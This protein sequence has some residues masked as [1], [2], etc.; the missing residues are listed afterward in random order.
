MDELLSEIE[1]DQEW[2]N[3][4]E[5]KILESFN[6]L[7]KIQGKDFRNKLIDAFNV[8]LAV[9]S[10]YILVISAVINKLHNASLLI[11]DIE[12][13]SDKRR[14]FPVAH[15]IFGTPS[16]INTANYIYFLAL[17]QLKSLNNSSL[18][19]IYN[20]EL[21]NL[22]R[23]QGM[24][25]YYRDNFICPSISQYLQLV[26]NKTSGL[27]RLSIKLLLTFSSFE[28]NLI[29]LI[30]KIGILFQIRDDYLNL[31]DS[32]SLN[33]SFAEDIT[34]GKFSFPIIHGILTDKDSIK[35]INILKQRTK[36]HDLKLYL[37][38]Y[39]KT[40][41]NSAEFTL[42]VIRKLH[43]Q[44]IELINNLGGNSLLVKILDDLL[45]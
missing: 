9:D 39:L 43:S 19:D 29:P 14:G 1:T 25:L 27:L 26:N 45:L 24:D 7:N 33:K 41:T 35:I 23:G 38:D 31:F 4:N 20:D 10:H 34:E 15:R 37:I 30:N 36:D 18:I 8:W 21:I 22:H 28:K 2:S 42:Q 44:S 16:T 17:D 5:I 40:R 11:D 13:H 12:D 6:Y 32:N 3:D